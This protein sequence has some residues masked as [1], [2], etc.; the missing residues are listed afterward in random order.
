[1]T[2]ATDNARKTR[3]RREE[4]ADA[5][6]DVPFNER[7]EVACPECGEA[8]E[9]IILTSTP[10]QYTPTFRNCPTWDCDAFLKFS[11]DG[12]TAEEPEGDDQQASLAAFAGG[13]R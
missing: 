6:I 10:R 4:R 12:S 5:T 11:W 13:E 7:V 3:Q 2:I 1:M 9:N 8:F